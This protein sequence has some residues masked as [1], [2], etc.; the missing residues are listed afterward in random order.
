MKIHLRKHTQINVWTM[1][2]EYVDI[3]TRGKICRQFRL[4]QCSS[5]IC[6]QVGGQGVKRVEWGLASC[7]YHFIRVQENLVQHPNNNISIVWSWV[8][9]R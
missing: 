7:E 5:F 2:I 3:L 6:H 4:L 9:Q 8:A 1:D